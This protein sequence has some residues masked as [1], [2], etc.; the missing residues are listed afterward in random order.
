MHKFFYLDLPISV[1]NLQSF[2]IN[3]HLQKNFTSLNGWKMRLLSLA[4]RFQLVRCSIQNFISYQLRANF[5]LKSY[6]KVINSW[7]SM[8]LLHGDPQLKKL[9][10]ISWDKIYRLRENE[11]L[12]LPSLQ[13]FSYGFTTSLC[14]IFL[15]SNGL[16]S[17]QWV[18][19][20]FFVL[21]PLSNKVSFFFE[22]S[23]SFCC[24]DEA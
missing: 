5:I 18:F 11:G 10:T 23:Q 4:G 6:I 7:C 13:T 16:F 1:K 9:S 8:F 3:P 21:K 24:F 2:D 19:K 12:G 17:E 20:Y 15:T 14:W 22:E